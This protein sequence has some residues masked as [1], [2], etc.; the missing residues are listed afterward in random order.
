MHAGRRFTHTFPLCGRRH[1]VPQHPQAVGSE[2]R[3][4]A[5][6]SRLGGPKAE[7]FSSLCSQDAVTRASD[8]IHFR[9]FP[10][11]AGSLSLSTGIDEIA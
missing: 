4:V 11:T 9:D 1:D 10:S 7:A 8:P 3:G 6:R 2:H 5:W